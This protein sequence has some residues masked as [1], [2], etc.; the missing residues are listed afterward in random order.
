MNRL[1]LASLVLAPFIAAQVCHAAEPLEVTSLDLGGCWVHQEPF[2]QPLWKLASFSDR[3]AVTISASE[4]QQTLNEPISAQLRPVFS[5]FDGS[6]TETFFHCSAGGHLFWTS[7]HEGT[8]P[9]C[10]WSKMQRNPDTG[11]PVLTVL[12]VL[13]DHEFRPDSPCA[14]VTRKSLIIV[15]NQGSDIDAVMQY[16]R[17]S[18]RYAGVF[19]NLQP[20]GRTII[21]ARLEDAYDFRE[22][23]AKALI[24][25]DKSL[26]ADLRA[27]QY[28]G[29]VSIVGEDQR[30]FTGNY[31]GF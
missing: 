29:R 13:P 28:D 3:V 19:T 26:A 16:F 21:I 22:N 31:P 20:I 14:G 6:A 27:V 18:E 8:V 12:D 30:L 7:I 11:F 10:V 2:F 15:I 24:E 1:T 25:S 4:F 5:S 17:T 9:L 23:V